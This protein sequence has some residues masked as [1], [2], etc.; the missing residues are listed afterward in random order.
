MVCEN[1]IKATLDQK[2]RIIEFEIEG[3]T[4]N[5]YNNQILNICSNINQLLIDVLKKHP[6]LQKY[7]TH[8][9]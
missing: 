2:A 8:H 4:L 7:D 5:N 1:R 9:I 3:Q 6:D